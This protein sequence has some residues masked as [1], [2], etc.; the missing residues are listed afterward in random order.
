MSKSNEKFFTALGW[1]ATCTSML[2]YVAYI[3]Q[4]VNSLNGVKGDFIQ[5]MAAGVNCTL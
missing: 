5:P 3:P 4:I 2:M 1:V